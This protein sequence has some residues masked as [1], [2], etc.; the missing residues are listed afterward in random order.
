M[1]NRTSEFMDSQAG[2]EGTSVRKTAIKINGNVPLSWYP[3]TSDS[4]LCALAR[5]LLALPAEEPLMLILADAKPGMRGCKEDCFPLSTAVPHGTH[6]RTVSMDEWHEMPASRFSKDKRGSMGEIAAL[7]TTTGSEEA[8]ERKNALL[9]ALQPLRASRKAFEQVVLDQAPSFLRSHIDSLT[10]AD[11]A[12][13]PTVQCCI[14]LGSIVDIDP[15]TETFVATFTL[16]LD[17]QDFQLAGMPKDSIEHILGDS[18]RYLMP[19]CEIGNA[20]VGHE[21]LD[22]SAHMRC[23][24]S[25]KGLVKITA[26][27]KMRLQCSMDVLAFP[28]DQQTLHIETRLR[29]IPLDKAQLTRAP[30]ASKEQARRATRLFI[31]LEDPSI[32]LVKPREHVV[33]HGADKVPQWGFVCDRKDNVARLKSSYAPLRNKHRALLRTLEKDQQVLEADPTLFNSMLDREADVVTKINAL[34]PRAHPRYDRRQSCAAEGMHVVAI[35]VARRPASV[36]WT[37]ALPVFLI[38]TVSFCLFR[39]DPVLLQDR[40]AVT[41]TTM[42]TVV[43]FQY[44]VRE[45]VPEVPY[46]TKMDAFILCSLSIMFLEASPGLNRG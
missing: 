45:M 21:L 16:L 7:L 10:C 23:D 9:P 35:V 31:V 26:K 42:L 15:R 30:N 6:C 5:T 46:N 8:N 37:L 1:D 13:V 29:S 36:L 28:F 41:L 12:L 38:T 40:L 2:G 11:S 20:V 43:A 14:H 3:G 32:A 25:R 4:T 33:A 18:A 17:W 34:L 22:K 19:R 27:V 44:V 24:D 39:I